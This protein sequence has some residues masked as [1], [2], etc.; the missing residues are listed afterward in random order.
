MRQPAVL[1]A[2]F[3]LAFACGGSDEPELYGGAGGAT[4]GGT[5]SG[6]ASSGGTTSGGTTSGGAGGASGTAGASAGS[7]GAAGSVTGGAAG[8]AD[9]GVG[10][11]SGG[12][13]GSAT[14]GSIQCGWTACTT[15]D[16]VCCTCPSCFPPFP[17]ACFPKITGCS[18]TGK[19]MV[20]DDAT[21]C[22][23]GYVCCAHFQ[24]PKYEFTGASCEASCPLEGNAQLCTTDAECPPDSTCKDLASLPGFKGCQQ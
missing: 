4:S 2:S 21:D 22:K 14:P 10:G 1:A 3:A 23:L 6:G 15:Q 5:T 12:Q 18:G 20:C 13:G 16:N 9:S 7:A 19:L 11:G 17:T 8:S 24:F